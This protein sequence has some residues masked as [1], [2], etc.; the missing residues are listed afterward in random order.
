[1]TQMLV[2]RW[3]ENDSYFEDHKIIGKDIPE[4]IALKIVANGDG[5]IIEVE[6]AEA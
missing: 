6:D 5:E 1:M 3:S 4:D 2:V